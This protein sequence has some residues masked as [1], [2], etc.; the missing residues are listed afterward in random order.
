MADGV[1]G[2]GDGVPVARDDE[3]V[4]DV[5][6]T[7]RAAG[8]DGERTGRAEPVLDDQVVPDRG[9]RDVV[10]PASRRTA[11]AVDPEVVPDPVAAASVQPSP[12]TRS[13]SNR[14]PLQLSAALA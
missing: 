5:V 6:A 1:A 2:D 3:I 8:A 7:S 13:H 4:A 9:A 14:R 11:D 12:S 10:A